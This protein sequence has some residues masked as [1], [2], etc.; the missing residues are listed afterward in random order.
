MADRHGTTA[1][2]LAIAFAP[3]GDRVASVLFGAPSAD[4]VRE[5][6]RALE[7][8]ADAVAELR[9][10]SQAASAVVRTLRWNLSQP[11]SP[12]R[13]PTVPL[14]RAHTRTGR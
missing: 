5:N 3:H 8:S 13:K 1:A 12:R 14:S 4:Q 10:V 9:E 6:T 11:R 2:A 7:V